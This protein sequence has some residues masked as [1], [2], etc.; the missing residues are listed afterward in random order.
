MGGDSMEDM[1]LDMALAILDSMEDM[2]SGVGRR[3]RQN[4]LLIPQLTLLLT[5]L[6]MPTMEPGAMVWVGGED[7]ED[8]EGTGATMD[9]LLHTG[10]DMAV[11]GV[12]DNLSKTRLNLRILPFSFFTK[13]I[14]E[15]SSSGTNLTY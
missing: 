8:G 5:L 2:D 10:V 1:V 3:E 4:Q 14:S 7:G 6:L 11:G 13:T 12:A 15:D 9:T